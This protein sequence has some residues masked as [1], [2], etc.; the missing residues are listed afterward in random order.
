MGMGGR[1]AEASWAPSA[2][3]STREEAETELEPC[4]PCSRVNDKGPPASVGVFRKLG[5]QLDPPWRMGFL[6]LP[7]PASLLGVWKE[8]WGKWEVFC[9]SLLKKQLSCSISP[10]TRPSFFLRQDIT[11]L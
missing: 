4:A 11:L 7:P 3:E 9:R 6:M 8:Q 10:S 1:E 2:W 5:S